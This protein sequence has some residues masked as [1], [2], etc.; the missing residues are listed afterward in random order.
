MQRTRTYT[1]Q[2]RRQQAPASAQLKTGMELGR[3]PGTLEDW[4]KVFWLQS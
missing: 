2:T 4:N 3:N 1:S